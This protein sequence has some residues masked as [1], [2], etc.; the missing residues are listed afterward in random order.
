MQQRN[1]KKIPAFTKV[2]CV[3][4]GLQN[5]EI[6]C[7]NLDY[8]I[9]CKI[10]ETL[11]EAKE[12]VK[13]KKYELITFIATTTKSIVI[14]I[15]TNNM[16]GDYNTFALK[17]T[18]IVKNYI[19]LDPS[20]EHYQLALDVENIKPYDKRLDRYLEKYINENTENWQNEEFNEKH[21]DALNKQ[22]NVLSFLCSMKSSHKPKLPKYVTFMILK[23]S[24][25]YF[26]PKLLAAKKENKKDKK[27]CV[28]F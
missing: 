5:F 16:I 11:N 18:G 2:F 8:G 15:K 9:D 21:K 4:T 22:K 10:F 13:E 6:L 25:L 27:K 28:T 14:D 26:D 24:D 12:F 17:I 20:H 3:Q 1:T 19:D 7:V 23:F